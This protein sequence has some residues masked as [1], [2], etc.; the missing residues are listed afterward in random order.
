MFCQC[1][2]NPCLTLVKLF[3]KEQ[4]WNSSSQFVNHSSATNFHD[5]VT[6]LGLFC[7]LLSFIFHYVV[8]IF[9]INDSYQ[10]VCQS[11]WQTRLSLNTFQNT[12]E[13][14]KWFL[15]KVFLIV[16]LYQKRHQTPPA[17]ST[18]TVTTSCRVAQVI[19]VFVNMVCEQT[20]IVWSIS[21]HFFY[22]DQKLQMNKKEKFK[23]V[24]SR[25]KIL[26]Q[27]YLTYIKLCGK[28]QEVF[29]V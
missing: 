15:T 20:H 10:Q 9:Q 18:R 12:N 4:Q 14:A 11:G 19:C 2:D 13:D 6:Y 22:S 16:F 23:G 7:N 1:L 25:K 28:C 17:F 26:F 27:N 8:N 5:V 24:V 29:I 21:A 3:Q